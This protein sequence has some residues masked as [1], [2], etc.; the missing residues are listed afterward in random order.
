MRTRSLGNGLALT[1]LG[2]GAAQFG[3]L[4]RATTDTEAEGAFEAAWQAGIRYFDTA[5]HYGLGLSE[6][7]LGALLGTKNRDEYVLSTK[8]GR[9]LVPNPGGENFQDDGGFEVPARTRRQWDFSAD[10]VKRSIDESLERLGLDRIDIVYLHDPDDHR[11]PPM[12]EALPALLHLREEGIVTAVG[13][14][15]NQSAMPA[16][17]IRRHDIDIV[18]LAGRYT[19]LEQGALT[20]LMPLAVEHGVG[21]VI[22]GVYNSGLLSRDR[23]APDAKYNYERAPADLV[24]R[25]HRIA[26]ICEQHGVSL[27]E[28]A[29]AFPLLHPATV[30]VVVGG[31]T[32]EQVMGSVERYQRPVPE[33]LWT[34]LRDQ[35]LIPA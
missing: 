31:R 18:M 12:N 19:L 20:D 17:F 22:A 5:P 28:A 21:I 13:A 25:A 8:A 32:D 9:L 2:L 4:Y 14:G 1:E 16:D 15:M 34:D 26:D 33:A 23:P 30:S 35:R 3:N 29:V 7:R 10:G 6:R 27:P 11:E 24:T